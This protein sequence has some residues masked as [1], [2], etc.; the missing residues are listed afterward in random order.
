MPGNL[1]PAKLPKVSRP[2]AAIRCINF[3]QRLCTHT[4]GRWAGQ[5]I[6]WHDWQREQWIRPLFG[7]HDADGVRAVK[8]AYIE[9]GKK[10]GKST[11]ASAVAIYMAHFIGELGAEVYCLAST[12]EQARIVQHQ[13]EHM[14]RGCKQ[15][16]QRA[17]IRRGKDVIWPQL[18]A[19]IQA[20]SGKGASGFNPYCLILDELHEWQGQAAYERWTYGS[21]ARTGWLHLAI[22]NA[23]DDTEGVCYR[24]REYVQKIN[25]GEVDA[26]DY[27][28]RIY[29][30][31]REQ[32]EAE[33]ESVG[34]GATRLPVA[35]QCNP[36][37][38]SI[39]QESDLVAEIKQALHIPANMP[40]L[41]RFWYC[42]WRTAADLEWLNRYWPDCK[43][44]Y[45]LDDVSGPLWLGLDMSSVTDLTALVAC[46]VT[47]PGRYRLYPWF[48]VPAMRA[49]EMR[50]WTA[51]DH[52]IKRG[53]ITVVPGER[54]NHTMI[55][56]TICELCE[57]HD[58]RGLVYDPRE[59]TAI[60]SD[61]SD[62]VGIDCFPFRQSHENYHEPTDNF[63]ADVKAGAIEHNGNPVLSWQA[64]H[65][66][67]KET[68]HGYKKPIKPDP[69][70]APHKGVDGVQAAVMGYS[71]AMHHDGVSEEG[72][73]VY[74]L[75]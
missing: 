26:P 41:L 51:I 49:A 25:R 30:A 14:V 37:L 50:K 57:T 67:C 63:E 11:F 60:V 13:V 15:L 44:D 33:I 53:H 74:V 12:E 73:G 68:T 38:G 29:G 6:E 18:N 54:I 52:W 69:L 28:G 32:A 66:L 42:V 4:K 3:V 61:V 31:T 48:W 7:W 46:S 40:N 56:D 5:A 2:E 35:A 1:K 59:A 45:G 8:R 24:Q 43:A 16:E 19:V 58:V 72:T 22:T 34:G 21:M 17:R 9:C 10:S 75:G 70:G 55:S 20:M 64:R 65:A 36:G 62:R 39:L 27:Y 47:A 71:Q 23:G